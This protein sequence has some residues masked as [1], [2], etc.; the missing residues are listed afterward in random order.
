M[1]LITRADLDGLACAVLLQE[2]ETIDEVEFAHPKDVQDGKVAVT[3]NDILANLPYDP[4]VG[5][6]FDHHAS[7]EDAVKPEG[8]H[9]AFE[10]APSAAR[11][12][13]D[14]Y[15]KPQFNKYEVFLKETDRLD[16]A[17]LEI[18]DVQDPKGWI[19]LGYTLD[20]R[21]GL[22]PFKE[23]FFKLMKLIQ[24][25]TIDEILQDP[26]VAARVQK[27]RDDE[28]AFLAHLK[29]VSN[30]E[31]NVIVTDVRG[32][33][34][35]PTGN[36]FLVYTIFPTVNV[37]MRIAD[38]KGGEFISIQVGHSIFNRTCNTHVGNL[39]AKY[40]GGGHKGAGTCQIV[41]AKAE[42]TIKEILGILIKNG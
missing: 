41:T 18:E 5:Y 28:V 3:K 24:T 20:P 30:L 27:V 4:R 1:R 32:K 16:S 10:I 35:L 14:Y 7:Q 34:G 17:N 25:S 31:G 39:M 12:I 23:Y 29:E 13:A 38:G 6:W 22:G 36:R 37:S 33:K 19:L 8:F 2:V 21:T 40:G 15:A 42:E 11:V 9:G 26:E